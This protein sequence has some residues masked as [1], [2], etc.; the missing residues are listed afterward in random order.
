MFPD[1]LAAGIESVSGVQDHV[2]PGVRSASV[3]FQT[4]PPAVAM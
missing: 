3:V 2:A 4:P 1:A